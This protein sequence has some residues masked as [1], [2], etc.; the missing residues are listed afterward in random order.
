[1]SA[2]KKMLLSPSLVPLPDLEG[3]VAIVTGSSRGLGKAMALRLAEAGCS[4]VVAAKSEH[5]RDSLPGSIH[6]TV[7]EIEAIGGKAS[8][9]KTNLR[10]EEDVEAMIS[11]A[12]DCFGRLDILINN[13]GALWVGPIQDTPAKRFDLVHEVNIR[14]S[15]LAARLAAGVMKDGGWIFTVSPPLDFGF[16]PGK[17][18]YGISKLSQTIMTMGL[19]VELKDAGITT[20]SFW[21]ATMVESQATINHGMGTPEM[22]RKPE[23]MADALLALLAAEAKEITGKAFLDEE[24][25]ALAGVTDLEPYNCVE[26]GKPFRIVGKVRW[27]S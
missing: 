5:S 18:G 23:V 13:A 12:M 21:P 15:F 8:A 25:L 11:M 6:E 1:M 16:L 20:A 22:W 17:L 14:A 2:S 9:V 4:V 24:A 27:P 19:A 3:K 26:G 7:A 10:K